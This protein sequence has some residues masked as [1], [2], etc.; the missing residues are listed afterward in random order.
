M[1]QR[2][3]AFK[4]L[5]AL[6]LLPLAA[7]CAGPAT[8]PASQPNESLLT[9]AGFKTIAADTPE[10]KRHLAWLQP[11]QVTAVQMTGK[12]Y[13]VLPDTAKNLLYVGTPKEYQAYLALRSKNGLPNPPPQNWDAAKMHRYIESQ[14]QKLANIN[15]HDA[16][17]P[18]WAIWPEFGNLGWVP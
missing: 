1:T 12:H 2:R 3:S 10:R 8:S 4:R 5:A 17:I 6:L 11:D 13:Y 9:A 16:S 14:D 15:A 18:S 7:G